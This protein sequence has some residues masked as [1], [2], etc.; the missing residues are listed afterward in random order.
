MSARRDPRAQ[1]RRPRAPRSTATDTSAPACKPATPEQAAALLGV[2]NGAS[3]EQIRAA[4]LQMVKKHPP[5]RAAA[6]FERIRD[7]YQ[8]LSDPRRLSE[9]RLLCGDP[10]APL[11]T[12]LDDVSP[13]RSHVGSA[14][15]LRVLEQ[16]Q[17]CPA[18]KTG[19]Q[20]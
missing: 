3:A 9:Q 2:P 20:D 15:W 11:A 18:A 14:P 16:R 13:A 4:Y 5:D 1:D 19:V 8:L 6:E 7:A 17:A 10:L 12:L